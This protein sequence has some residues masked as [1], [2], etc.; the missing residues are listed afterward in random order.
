MVTKKTAV[1]YKNSGIKGGGDMSIKNMHTADVTLIQKSD[2][3]MQNDVMLGK[4]DDHN[5]AAGPIRATG[6]I[7]LLFD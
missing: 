6:P 4:I 5:D 3:I 1:A 2:V 7:F